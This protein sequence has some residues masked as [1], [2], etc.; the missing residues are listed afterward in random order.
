MLTCSSSFCKMPLLTFIF[1]RAILNANQ[2]VFKVYILSYLYFLFFLIY[3]YSYQEAYLKHF[4]LST[5][6][7][8][9]RY[10]L[11]EASIVRLFANISKHYHD[12]SLCL[13]LVCTLAVINYFIIVV[14]ETLNPKSSV[15]LSKP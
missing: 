2:L 9:Y 13:L 12:I 8:N 10:F 7:I 3:R 1:Q 11:N 5:V 14:Q 4:L 15:S 6:I